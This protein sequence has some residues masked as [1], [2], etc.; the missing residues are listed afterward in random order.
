[1]SLALLAADWLKHCRAEGKLASTMHGYAYSINGILLPWCERESIHEPQDLTQARLEQLGLELL[2]RKGHQGEPISKFTVT[3]YLRPI[4]HFTRWLREEGYDAPGAPLLPRARKPKPKDVLTRDEIQRMEDA[5]VNER[6]KLIIRV[7]G[8][9][10]MR[11]GEL[12]ALRPVDLVERNRQ[13]FLY[14]Q[15]KGE[16]DRYVPVPRVWRRL[17]RWIERGRR[18]PC[19]DRVFIALRGNGYR[20]AL[21]YS[22][23]YEVVRGA[24]EMADFGK[25]AHPHLLRHSLITHLRRKGY[26]DAQVSLIVGNFSHL[27][28]YTWLDSADAYGLV[29][30]LE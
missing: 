22:G 26:N 10:G 13:W 17:Q 29:A 11:I 3:A 1:M 6:D 16:N 20:P 27:R 14:V 8:D 12:C 23:A 19:A 15:G 30:D 18:Q 24:A 4:R 2:S 28:T 9:T 21:G 5:T 7:L 25:R